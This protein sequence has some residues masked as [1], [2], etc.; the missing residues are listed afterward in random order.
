MVDYLM[1]SSQTLW[2]KLGYIV[3]II[4]L[5]SD[6]ILDTQPQNMA[7]THSECFKLE[8]RKWQ[9]HEGHYDLPSTPLS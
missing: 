2:D 7:H 8:L 6:E 4:S 9:K 5:P 1:E 3:G